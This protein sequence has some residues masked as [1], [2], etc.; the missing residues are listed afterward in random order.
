MNRTCLWVDRC[1]VTG[2]NIHWIRN[3]G[4]QMMIQP[5]ANISLVK[6][7]ITAVLDEVCGGMYKVRKGSCRVLQAGDDPAVGLSC[8]IDS[9]I[10]VHLLGM[11]LD[12]L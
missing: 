7:S 9:F 2:D 11:C 4:M 10:P 12:S 6:H 5:D 8:T 3:A 1:I